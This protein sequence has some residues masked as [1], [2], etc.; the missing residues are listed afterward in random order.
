MEA[1]YYKLSS[2]EHGFVVK[3]DISGNIH[4]ILADKH[5]NKTCGLCGNLNSFGEDDFMTQEGEVHHYSGE[6]WTV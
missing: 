6:I 3:A 4:I 2:E 1:G 5:Y